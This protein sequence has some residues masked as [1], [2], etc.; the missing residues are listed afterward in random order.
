[1]HCTPIHQRAVKPR[2]LQSL[3]SRP[4]QSY[5]QGPELKF[6]L[7]C[8]SVCNL[9]CFSSNVKSEIPLQLFPQGVYMQRFQFGNPDQDKGN[10]WLPEFWQNRSAERKGTGRAPLVRRREERHFLSHLKGISLDPSKGQQTDRPLDRTGT[11]TRT[12]CPPFDKLDSSKA[13]DE[14]AAARAFYQVPPSLV[15]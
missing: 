6:G 5:I 9:P 2:E 1:M 3:L 8:N 12:R 4:W 14:R 11:P 13:F 10:C 15:D 7:Q